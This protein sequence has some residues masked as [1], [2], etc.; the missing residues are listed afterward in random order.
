MNFDLAVF[1][2]LLSLGYIFGTL[3]E[4]S[5]YASIRRRERQLLNLPALTLRTLPKTGR[6]VRETRLVTGNTVVVMDY[7]KRFLA[8]LKM[9]FGGRVSSYESLLDR[10][11]REA[12]LRMKAEAKGADMILNVRIETSTIGKE[13]SQQRSMG[14]IEALAYG[15]AVY[16][17]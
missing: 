15:T 11:R 14:S 5:H 16:Y 12:L 8:S 10:A 9:I 7:L 13:A 3:A 6:I 1:L 2:I 4:R 17:R